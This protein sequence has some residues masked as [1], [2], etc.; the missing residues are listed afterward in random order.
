MTTPTLIAPHYRLT[1]TIVAQGRGSRAARNV[2]HNP[3]V[4]VSGILSDHRLRPETNDQTRLVGSGPAMDATYSYEQA[5]TVQSTDAASLQ[6]ITT[7]LRH[8]GQWPVIDVGERGEFVPVTTTRGVRLWR[9]RVA[10]FASAHQMVWIQING[11]AAMLTYSDYLM[12]AFIFMLVISF[13]SLERNDADT[14]AFPSGMH[15]IIITSQMLMLSLLV[16]WVWICYR[17]EDLGPMAVG[18][19][20]LGAASLLWWTLKTRRHWTPSASRVP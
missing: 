11:P 14:G 16:C 8:A 4:F 3:T 12:F 9:L 19:A 5:L 13:G 18:M 2:A 6:G 10:S 20:F 1:I 7:E 15:P 17:A